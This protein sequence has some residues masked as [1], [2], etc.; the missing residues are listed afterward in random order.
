[1]FEL[2]GKNKIDYHDMRQ[3][4]GAKYKPYSRSAVAKKRKGNAWGKGN[5]WRGATGRTQM[6][7]GNNR[8][9]QPMGA[10]PVSTR[11]TDSLSRNKWFQS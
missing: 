5:Q 8:D 11:P 2:P 6:S 7:L 4:T 1:M 3:G 9:K 10:K